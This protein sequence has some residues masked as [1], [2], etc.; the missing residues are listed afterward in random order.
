MH[1][2]TQVLMHHASVFTHVHVALY[3]DRHTCTHTPSCKHTVYTQLPHPSSLLL[4][5]SFYTVCRCGGQNLS[6]SRVET[7]LEVSV[8]DPHLVTVEHSLQDLLD[9]VTITNS[10]QV[11]VARRGAAKEGWKGRSTVEHWGS[12]PSLGEQGRYRK[13]WGKE[14]LATKEAFL[15]PKGSYSSS[16]SPSEGKGSGSQLTPLRLR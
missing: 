8:D 15:S 10:G 13:S 1:A 2:H 9:A 7:H 4:H 3:R 11:R 5:T 16:C 14:M 12:I 6:Q